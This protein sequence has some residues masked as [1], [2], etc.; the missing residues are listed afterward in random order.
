MRVLHTADWHLGR[1]IRGRSRQDEFEAVLAEV[2]AIV[3]SERVDLLL[4]AGD[5]FDTFSPAPEAEKLLYET[6]E[7]MVRE[8]AQVVLLAG[9]HDHARHMDALTRVLRLAGIHCFG[10][11]TAD[12]ALARV[13]IPSR[14]RSE[15]AQIVALPWVPERFTF[16]FESL[17]RGLEKPLAQYAER[18]E[19]LIRHLW[20]KPDPK[21]VNIFAGHMLI[22]GAEIGPGGGERQ[23]QIGQ[24]F[25]VKASALPDDAE[26]VAL[27]HVHKPQQIAAASR[28]EYSGSLLQLDFG[29]ADQKRSVNLVELRPG[30]PPDVRRLELKGGRPLR[31]VTVRFADLP[32]LA[33]EHAGA[34]LKVTVELD[35]FV[36]ALAQKV[37][38]LVPNAVE[39]TPPK[40]PAAAS[41]PDPREQRRGLQPHELFASFYRSKRGTD[42]PA[43]L[44]R[45][46]NQLL[47]EAER[48]SP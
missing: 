35:E 10:S 4:V 39:V 48:A 13:A 8:G 2:A 41:G 37:H 44:V 16:D 17:A 31:N 14:D 33:E 32:R 27:G 38:D 24:N 21:A 11:V 34:Y 47:T 28:V 1:Q 19:R 30:L 22:S 18:M 25:A 26:Y 5:I 29:E 42:A 40:L 12:P 23:L 9:N 36:P 6:L 15:V 7:Q 46:F 20:S 3:R 43:E 45:L